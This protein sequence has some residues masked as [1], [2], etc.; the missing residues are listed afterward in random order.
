MYDFVQ[1]NSSLVDI[2]SVWIDER[3]GLPTFD[4]NQCC[5]QKKEEGACGGA[6]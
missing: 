5:A 3:I 4:P 1:K 6:K 2:L